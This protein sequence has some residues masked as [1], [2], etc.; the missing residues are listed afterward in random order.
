MLLELS[1]C[2]FILTASS[3]RSFLVGIVCAA[4]LEGGVAIGSANIGRGA[5]GACVCPELNALTVIIPQP[6]CGFWDE[7]E[8]CGSEGHMDLNTAYKNPIKVLG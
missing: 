5:G 3:R 8:G 6:L 2:D 4:L 7:I 1:L